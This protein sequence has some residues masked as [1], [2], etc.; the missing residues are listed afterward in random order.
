LLILQGGS[1]LSGFT[2]EPLQSL[3]LMFLKLNTYA[4]EIDLVFFGFW[5]ILTG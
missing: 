1:F 3:T 2:A 5:C 4:F